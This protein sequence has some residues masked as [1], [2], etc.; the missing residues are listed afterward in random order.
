M[1]PESPGS[2]SEIREPAV[3]NT[4]RAI[5]EIAAR[6]RGVV[7]R[8]QLLAAGIHGDAIK[9]RLR[10]GRLHPMHRGVYLVGHPTPME[11][12]REIAA[13]L[14]CGPGAVVSHRSAGYLWQLL[15]YPAKPGPVDVTVPGREPARRAGIRIHSV[16]ALARC[17]IRTIRRIPITIPAR[18]LLDLATVLP[19]YLLE[20][21]VAEAQVRRFVTRADVLDQLERNHGRR[22]TRALR[23]VSELD[24]GPTLTRSGQS[25]GC[26]ASSV[27]PSSRLHG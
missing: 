16:E 13:V 24:G 23:V 15:P 11:R 9:R 22:G 27:P 12:A 19:P 4:D 26:F 1:R 8:A 21:A 17:D 2:C 20:R 25:S 18:T 10:S 7:S 5:A 3:R 6:Q 14:A